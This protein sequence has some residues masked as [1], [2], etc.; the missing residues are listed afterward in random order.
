MQARSIG[1]I[2]ATVLH[3]EYDDMPVLARPARIDEPLNVRRK[4]QSA[5]R[6]VY[7]CS[8]PPRHTRCSGPAPGQAQ[9]TSAAFPGRRSVHVRDPGGKPRIVVRPRPRQPHKPPMTGNIRSPDR[10]IFATGSGRHFPW[11]GT[12][13]HPSW[14]R[15]AMTN[16]PGSVT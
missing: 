10:K 12:H 3:A 5:E 7:A 11:P 9:P 13:V 4:V 15:A 6:A 16:N 8:A 2:F 1:P 14:R